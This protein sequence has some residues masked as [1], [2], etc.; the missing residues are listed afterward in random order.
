VAAVRLSLLDNQG[1]SVS[2]P[3]K[4]FLLDKNGGSFGVV[5]L[6][7]QTVDSVTP[8]N[9]NQRNGGDQ[10]TGTYANYPTGWVIELDG[11]LPTDKTKFTN[12]NEGDV[13]LPQ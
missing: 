6:D 2:N 10:T 11:L 13:P 5:L 12:L 7:P 8:R 3:T 4:P 9:V 1:S